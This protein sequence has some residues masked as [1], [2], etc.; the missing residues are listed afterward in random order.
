MGFN[1]G[2][3]GLIAVR[4][5]I[6]WW[7]RTDVSEETVAF[8]ITVDLGNTSLSVYFGNSFPAPFQS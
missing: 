5:Q 7:N 6:Y 3:K 1:L 8:L 4:P 2:F